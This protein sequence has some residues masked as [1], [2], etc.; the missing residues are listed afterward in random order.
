MRSSRCGGA[1]PSGTVISAGGRHVRAAQG[2]AK[3][4][5]VGSPTAA[6]CLGQAGL[7]PADTGS[8]R[9]DNTSCRIT[10]HDAPLCCFSGDTKAGDRN[11]ADRGEF[12]GHGS[13]APPSG[14][15]T[16]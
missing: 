10:F 7:S 4:A 9:R 5:G 8:V 16:H 14:E 11:R 2:N 3:H 12:G 1:L 6:A 15:A 13:C